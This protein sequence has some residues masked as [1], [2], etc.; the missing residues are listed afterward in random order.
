MQE[1][2]EDDED[3]QLRRRADE[4][5]VSALREMLKRSA[6]AHAKEKARA[7]SLANEVK[8]LRYVWLCQNR[9]V[10]MHMQSRY[11]IVRMVR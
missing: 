10:I 5:D 11:N 1:E 2:W 6:D 9:C 8:S 4:G 3:K 7:D